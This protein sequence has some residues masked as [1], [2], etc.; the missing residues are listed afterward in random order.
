M[1]YSTD[2][3]LKEKEKIIRRIIYYHTAVLG[4][5]GPLM[6]TGAAMHTKDKNGSTPES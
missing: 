3:C 6:R 2:S 1:G 5:D 4:R